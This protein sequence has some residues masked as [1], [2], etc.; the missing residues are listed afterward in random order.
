MD[1]TL[2][3][4]VTLDHSGF[5]DYEPLFRAAVI[6][7][8]DLDYRI[9]MEFFIDGVCSETWTW[10]PA[11]TGYVEQTLEGKTKRLQ[12]TWARKA[13]VALIKLWSEES[14]GGLRW[15]VRWADTA[16]VVAD[17]VLDSTNQADADEESYMFVFR[18]AYLL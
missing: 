15:V 18:M 4:T 10:T 16:G 3:R 17:H 12:I 5:R 7:Q 2:A 9:L 13:A 11:M 8:P 14:A 1:Q 6:D